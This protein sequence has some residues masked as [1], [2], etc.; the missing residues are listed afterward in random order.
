MDF[1]PVY[2]GPI[3]KALCERRLCDA[4]RDGSYLIRDS[5]S[6]PGMYCL[7][8]L[9]KGYVYTYRLHQDAEGSWAADT[10]PDQQKR[11]FRK[12]KNLISAFEKPDQGIAIPLL[13]PVP[14]PLVPTT[15]P[16]MSTTE[17]PTPPPRPAGQNHNQNHNQNLPQGQHQHKSTPRVKAKKRP[18]V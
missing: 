12:V 7:C 8:V 3:G 5:E 15:P 10:A 9:C 6:V 2:H 11:L 16:Y 17:Q 18:S 1:V 4:G 14:R 13:Y